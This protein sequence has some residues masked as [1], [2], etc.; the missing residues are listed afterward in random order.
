MELMNRV[1]AELGRARRPRG[2]ASSRGRADRRASEARSRPAVAFALVVLAAAC[3]RDAT[4]VRPTDT[5]TE[6]TGSTLRLELV[7]APVSGEAPLRVRLDAR[8]IGDVGDPAAF[9]CPTLAWTLDDRDDGEV[10]IAQPQGCVP[11]TVARAFTLE[12]TYA[13]ARKYQASVRLIARDVPPSNGVEIV[14]RGATPTPAPQ[15]AFPGPTIVIA[16]PAG[17]TPA[18]TQVAAV[19]A[20]TLPLAG[21]A[22]AATATPALAQPGST[23]V[24]GA[25]TGVVS[26]ASGTPADRSTPS[27]TDLTRVPGTLAAV[28]VA[29]REATAMARPTAMLVTAAPPIEATP[30]G[31]GRAAGTARTATAPTVEPQV[32]PGAVDRTATPPLAGIV[33]ERTPAMPGR[34]S[35]TSGRA[36]APAPRPT[37]SPVGGAVGREAAPGLPAAPAAPP[38]RSPAPPLGSPPPASSPPSVARGGSPMPEATTVGPAPL[39]PTAGPATARRPARRV[40]PAD[41]YYL[42]GAPAQLWRLPVTGEPP[43]R[44]TDMPHPVDAYAVSQTGPVAFTSAGGL[45][46]LAPATGA[47]TPLDPGGAA[48]V[49]SRSGYQLAYTAGGLQVYDLVRRQHFTMAQDGVPLAWS[50]DGARLLARRAD[51]RLALIQVATQSAVDLPLFGIAAAG[52]LPDRDVAWLTDGERLDLLTAGAAL[53]VNRV[54]GLDAGLSIA[55]DVMVRPDG[56]LLV[57]ARSSAGLTAF[58]VDLASGSVAAVPSGPTTPLPGA[59]FDWAPDGRHAA[60]A[61]PDGVALVD[62]IAGAQVQMVAGPARQPRWVLTR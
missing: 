24:P 11:G 56:R 61:G 12:H 9:G 22:P 52:W 27:L 37:A 47:I 17:I 62:P 10:V 51:G 30:G 3:T 23:E 50:R 15:V 8:L 14:V 21:P 58:G 20:P 19:V 4:R 35:A 54:S 44:L 2:A 25:P 26:T 31:A 39:S 43:S 48:P 59:D 5:P 55:D 7:A 18:P 45:Y 42:A 41:L 13:T 6:P 34:P 38:A 1:N 16:T 53:T 60:L 32:S 46:L 49:W 29:P 28:V 36:V 40:L 33:A 57:A